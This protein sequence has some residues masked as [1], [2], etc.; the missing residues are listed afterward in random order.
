MPESVPN[1]TDFADE[2]ED[3]DEFALPY[4][5]QAGSAPV[6]VFSQ[7]AHNVVERSEQ[8]ARERAHQFVTS[9]D[10]FAALV[11]EPECAVSYVLETLQISGSTLV[12]QLAFILGRNSTD[13]PSV[14]VAYSPRTAAII[15][16]AQTEA[17][18]RGARCVETSHLLMALLRD[19]RGVPALLLE[20]PGLGLEPLGAALNR[21]MREDISDK[22]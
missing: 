8:L 12:Q 16:F 9:D 3:D 20:T 10:L 15:A 21:A 17:G 11:T 22:Q 4:Q 7:S 1:E 6:E 19:R 14:D 5:E 18:R 2:R 13:A